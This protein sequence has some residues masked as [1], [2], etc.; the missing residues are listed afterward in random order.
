M[1]DL[2]QNLELRFKSKSVIALITV[3]E[4]KVSPTCVNLQSAEP[5]SGFEFSHKLRQTIYLVKKEIGNKIAPRGFGHF[6]SVLTCLLNEL[7][8]NL[9]ICQS[10][11]GT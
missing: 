7:L 11:P 1:L 5:D 8:Y 2:N 10:K 6:D 9:L 3:N 4:R